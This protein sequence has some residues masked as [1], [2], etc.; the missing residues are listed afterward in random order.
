MRVRTDAG[1]WN[2]IAIGS[3]TGQYAQ[4]IRNAN[5]GTFGSRTC[6]H[7]EPDNR[8]VSSR[9]AILVALSVLLTG[10]GP[11]ASSV[12]NEPSAGHDAATPTTSSTPDPVVG[13]L[14]EQVKALQSQVAELEAQAAAT[15]VAT[16]SP[17]P[18]P[19]A[20][21]TAKPTAVPEPT[22]KP[23]YVVTDWI[24]GP[25]YGTL[26]HWCP[27]GMIAVRGENYIANGDDTVSFFKYPGLH[28]LFNGR[29]KDSSGRQ[30]WKVSVDPPDL[31]FYFE[32]ACGHR[33]N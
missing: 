4:V 17:S 8:R 26:I 13:A 16:P 6:R 5:Q 22:P 18:S 27:S 32:A 9:A 1:S 12:S 25:G 19:T 28:L 29:V 15:P 20:P 23:V 21:P 11:G 3:A 24:T 7:A 31:R 33:K 30:G 14:Q 10:C 2:E